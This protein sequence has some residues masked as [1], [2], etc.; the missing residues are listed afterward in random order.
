MPSLIVYDTICSIHVLLNSDTCI[1]YTYVGY[2]RDIVLT[3]FLHTLST[4]IRFRMTYINIHGLYRTRNTRRKH[5]VLCSDTNNLGRLL[6]AFH[7]PS[8]LRSL[9]VIKQFY[10]TASL[11][12]F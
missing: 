9:R 8:T 1:V 12:M 3:Q 11:C 7:P 10:I 2:E 6:P 4:R 5:A